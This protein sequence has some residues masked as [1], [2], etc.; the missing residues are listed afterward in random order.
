K[1]EIIAL[2]GSGQGVQSWSGVEKRSRT[3]EFF[4][5]VK[6]IPVKATLDQHAD[7]LVIML[8][9][10]DVLA[11]Y[12]MNDPASLQK[13]TDNYR[14]LIKSLQARLTPEVT[15]LATPTLCTE[16]FYSPKNRMM[17]KLIKRATAL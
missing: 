5:D 1:P 16:D 2:G 17:D 8:G 6:G 9:M 7:V 12:V 4:L 15:A 3:E 10:N 14:E 13:W 11:P